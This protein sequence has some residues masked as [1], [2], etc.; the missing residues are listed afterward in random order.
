MR[1]SIHSLRWRGLLDLP[2]RL[3][4]KGA[5]TALFPILQAKQTCLAIGGPAAASNWHYVVEDC[6]AQGVLLRLAAAAVPGSLFKTQILP[7]PGLA[8]QNLHF[9]KTAR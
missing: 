5:S 7:T 6:A 9:Y 4:V 1:Q 8:N 3:T 2:K